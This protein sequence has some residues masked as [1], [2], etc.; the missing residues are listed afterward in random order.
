MPVSCK[1]S[2]LQTT[3]TPITVFSSDNFMSHFILELRGLNISSE[4][5]A[6]VNGFTVFL[7]LTACPISTFSSPK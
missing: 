7:S 3:H 1:T 6:V 2:Q 5:K 4:L